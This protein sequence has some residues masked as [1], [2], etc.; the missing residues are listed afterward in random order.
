MNLKK[1]DD[2]DEINKKLH[3][4]NTINSQFIREGTSYHAL[5]NKKSNS[6]HCKSRSIPI[7]VNKKNN[8]F[9]ELCNI[10]STPPNSSP[11]SK[12][13]FMNSMYHRVISSNTLYSEE[14]EK[15]DGTKEPN[16]IE[17]EITSDFVMGVKPSN[18]KPDDNI[19]MIID[20]NINCSNYSDSSKSSKSKESDDTN[21]RVCLLLNM[22]KSSL[23]LPLDTG[24]TTEFISCNEIKIIED[25]IIP[26]YYMN[27][28]NTKGKLLDIDFG[29]TILDSIRN[30][31]ALTLYQ[32]EF[33]KTLSHEK[34]L[35]I[36]HEYDNIMKT[37]IPSLIMEEST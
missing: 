32:R 8:S 11:S 10:I 6:D 24:I 18:P 21:C 12:K 1:S 26:P 16:I 25:Y 19:S 2:T 4:N 31:R 37:Y 23:D 3:K 33:L 15:Q 28:Q 17:N 27:E 13:S 36:I 30:L 35:E 14:N 34:L 20:S 7:Y 9:N 29:W 22:A 5:P